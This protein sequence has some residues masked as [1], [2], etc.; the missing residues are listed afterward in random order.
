M[1]LSQKPNQSKNLK[2]ASFIVIMLLHK[3]FTLIHPQRKPRLH[4]GESFTLTD[5]KCCIL[6]ELTHTTSLVHSPRITFSEEQ[7]VHRWNKK[8]NH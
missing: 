6:T 5:M 3:E 7:I 8:L 2:S 1:S 4:F